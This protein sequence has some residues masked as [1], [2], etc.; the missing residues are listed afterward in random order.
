MKEKM[1]KE[2]LNEIKAKQRNQ[3]RGEIKSYRNEMKITK[4]RKEMKKGWKKE[5]IFKKNSKKEGCN[6]WWNVY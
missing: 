4:V 1:E 5:E 6:N 2:F 3:R